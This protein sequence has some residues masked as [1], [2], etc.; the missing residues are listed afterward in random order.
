M[1]L[2]HHTREKNVELGK[3]RRIR[4]PNSDPDQGVVPDGLTG[5]RGKDADYRKTQAAPGGPAT[6]QDD[7]CLGYRLVQLIVNRFGADRDDGRLGKESLELRNDR[8]VGVAAGKPCGIDAQQESQDEGVASRRDLGDQPIGIA[9]LRDH[10]TDGDEILSP[11]GNV[12]ERLYFLHI[13]DTDGRRNIVDE[14]PEGRIF[15]FASNDSQH[16]QRH[17]A[18]HQP[19]PFPCAQHKRHSSGVSLEITASPDIN[20]YKCTRRDF[21]PL[22]G[23]S[24][25][26]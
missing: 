24:V 17:R 7:G 15:L 3:P 22:R 10:H 25:I 11:H 26:A 12:S 1:W 21:R 16:G 23:E 14:R 4:G 18:S 5:Q 6:R 8:N 13:D 20:S 19:R 9:N 2:S